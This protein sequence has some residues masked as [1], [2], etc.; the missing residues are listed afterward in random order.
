MENSRLSD[1]YL[2]DAFNGKFCIGTALNSSQIWERNKPAI[3]VIKTHFNSIVAENC[4][5]S[6]PIQPR[7]GEF[8]FEEADKFVEFGEQNNMFII[9]HTLIWHSQTPEWFFIDKDGN[10]VSREV[11]IERMKKHISTVVGRYKGRVQ[12]WD[13]LNEAVLDNGKLRDSKFLQIIGK[14]Y[15]RL[16]FEF[17]HEADPD[18]ELYYNDYSMFIPDKREG[19]ISMIKE[20]KSQNIRVDGIGMQGH[21]DVDHPSLELYE[22]AIIRYSELGVNVMI[23]ELDISPLPSP[24]G[25]AGAE[26]SLNYEY[27]KKMNPYPN[28]LPD[29]IAK[30]LQN[31]YTDLF[32]L[33]LKHHDKISR[34]TLWGV[35]DGDSWRNNWPIEGRTDY[36][37][38]FDREYKAKSTVRA[39]TGLAKSYSDNE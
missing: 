23:T 35:G 27:Q 14:D 28:G 30:K 33:F 1:I 6:G 24:W 9:G 37:L 15:I 11:L 32:G 36:P 20:L 26:V 8:N 29:D 21:L 7:E 18:A 17:A 31:R 39:I 4:M 12:G 13:V 3:E 22:K 38:L 5:K 2:K 34:V 16:A 10:D 19:V 25:N